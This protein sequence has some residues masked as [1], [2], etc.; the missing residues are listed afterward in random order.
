MP[1]RQYSSSSPHRVVVVVFVD[2]LKLLNVQ[3]AAAAWALSS[4]VIKMKWCDIKDQ[5]SKSELG[6]LDGIWVNY[7]LSWNFYLLLGALTIATL[8]LCILICFSMLN[9][10]LGST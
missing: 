7:F 10:V 2:M 3:L 6:L 4:Q 5:N 1:P 8:A 9:H